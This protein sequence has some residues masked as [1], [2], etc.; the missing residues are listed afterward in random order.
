MHLYYKMSTSFSHSNSCVFLRFATASCT[1]IMQRSIVRA[2][3]VVALKSPHP[4]G[5]GPFIFILLCF[6]LL[7]FISSGSCLCLLM[8]TTNKLIRKNLTYVSLLLYINLSIR[9]NIFD[10]QRLPY[11]NHPK[12]YFTRIH[13]EKK[14]KV[15]DP[16]YICCALFCVWSLHCDCAIMM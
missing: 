5:I 14:S 2:R 16:S 15:A 8:P 10:R 7:K 9:P 6:M 4:R 12:R 13:A 1:W 11:W 3:N